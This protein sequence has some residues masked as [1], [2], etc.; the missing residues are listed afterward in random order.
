MSQQ[1]QYREYV[2]TLEAGETVK[3]GR[4]ANTL[5]VLG[6]DQTLKFVFD[7]QSPTDIP[8]GLSFTAPN[9]FNRVT[10]TNPHDDQ[11]KVTLGFSTGDVR[12]ARL[13][14]P[15]DLVAFDGPSRK[16]T[17]DMTA[18]PSG[19]RKVIAER[20]TERLSLTVSN[21]GSGPIF[22]GDE[23]VA[24]ARGLP[25]AAGYT[26]TIKTTDQVYAYTQSALT[27]TISILEETK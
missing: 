23:D 18:L 2:Y 21:F 22:I 25:I 7:E 19:K 14:L 13:T 11:V 9:Q 3:I 10:V 20:N 1:P 16:I 4:A 26:A 15:N 27:Q 17:T 8:A 24:F 6:S 5:T 12:D